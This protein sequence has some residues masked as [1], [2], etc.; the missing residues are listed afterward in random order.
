MYK[1]LISFFILFCLL[2]GCSASYQMETK[3]EI[4]KD[5]SG[6]QTF[7]I[8]LNKEDYPDYTLSDLQTK[9]DSLFN[10][11]K[12]E[13][14]FIYSS[15]ISETQLFMDI[16]VP[17]SNI[18]EYNEKFNK[19]TGQE[20]GLELIQ[21]G[22]IFNNTT[23]F[24][25]VNDFRSQYSEWA[26]DM[27]EESGLFDDSI[28][29]DGNMK[30]NFTYDNNTFD[31]HDYIID[32]KVEVSGVSVKNK[33]NKD[34]TLTRELQ[35]IFV[36]S[37]YLNML[38]ENDAITQQLDEHI[39]LYPGIT[40]DDLVITSNDLN[41]TI[42]FTYTVKQFDII[43][44][45]D[46][47]GSFFIDSIS[48]EKNENG[49]HLIG[50]ETV[51]AEEMDFYH[52]RYLNHFESEFF[53]ASFGVPEILYN[54]ETKQYV[55]SYNENISDNIDIELVEA[56]NCNFEFE[57]YKIP[58][59]KKEDLVGTEFTDNSFKT[60]FHNH[61]YY[62]TRAFMTFEKDN[63]LM[64][65]II[66][67]VIGL[68]TLILGVI[69]FILY[70]KNK[71]K[72]NANLSKGKTEIKANLSKGKDKLSEYN[73]KLNVMAENDRKSIEEEINAS[74]EQNVQ[75]EDISF[76]N[77][78]D[79]I[80]SIIFNRKNH[81][82]TLILISILGVITFI[83]IP[84]FFVIFSNTEIPEFGTISEIISLLE[85]TFEIPSYLVYAYIIYKLIGFTISLFTFTSFK[86]TAMSMTMKIQLN[87][88]LMSL[89]FIIVPLI[90]ITTYYKKVKKVDSKTLA[91]K[92]IAASFS[93][94]LILTILN[95]IFNFNLE[96][97]G[98]IKQILLMNI[99]SLVILRS[100]KHNM[101]FNTR[102][103]Y[104]INKIISKFKFCFIVALIPSLFFVFNAAIFA[105]PNIYIYLVSIMSTGHIS[106][107]FNNTILSMAQF[108]EMFG[109]NS[110]LFNV[111][112]IICIIMCIINFVYD[113]KEVF[114]K[115]NSKTNNSYIFALI[116]TLLIVGF[117]C[118]LYICF[119]ISFATYTESNMLG[120]LLSQVKDAS[121]IIKTNYLNIP[122]LYLIIL[123][124]DKLLYKINVF[125][126]VSSLFYKINKLL[127]L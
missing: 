68:I 34:F 53:Q 62:T 97:I 38:L 61:E 41:T 116:Y 30:F 17:F 64:N 78:I 118:L 98:M 110:T 32:N 65:Y 50:Q 46:E 73:N 45:E 91:K 77:I 20:F 95:L 86:F 48:L 11:V 66:Y 52:L 15:W 63:T 18:D 58:K 120:F 90:I 33:V 47:F 59:V 36:N 87:Y 94:P 54:T 99:I 88:F 49:E 39:K 10:G 109:I 127:K 124:Y 26:H 56:V 101:I 115:S 113:Y 67:A 42:N 43:K 108:A 92:L 102:Y 96:I 71:T 93:Y 12:E 112:T 31:D 8:K 111:V 106:L 125:S 81:S 117:S 126:L 84:L 2:T 16:S 24:N 13:K 114:V 122:Y 121:F 79:K 74:S 69:S 72:I 105:L 100:S 1:K 7:N 29:F 75:Y 55:V 40:K 22:N 35:Y 103:D 44:S 4:Q 19:I 6:I 9:L 80:K 83:L 89:L 76:K 3:L 37:D 85:R 60:V 5:T 57:G 23:Y 107:N 27:I 70:K 14:G 119:K 25:N 104:L 51:S 123:A 82:I 28:S 21:T